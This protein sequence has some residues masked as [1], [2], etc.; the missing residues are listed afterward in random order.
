M[1]KNIKLLNQKGEVLKE[2]Q[3]EIRNQVHFEIQLQNRKSLTKN[4]K[5]YDRKK[6]KLEL[7]KIA[8]SY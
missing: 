3:V 5:A 7:K 1:K 6:S 8:I 2:G 4:K